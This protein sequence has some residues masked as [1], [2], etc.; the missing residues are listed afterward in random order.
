MNTEVIMPNLVWSPGRTAEAIRTAA[1]ACLC[2][3]LQD[4][5]Q[6]DKITD[7]GGGGN[8]ATKVTRNK[9]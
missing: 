8:T 4:N 9:V 7:N 5:P 1:I 3:A 2:S 6:D